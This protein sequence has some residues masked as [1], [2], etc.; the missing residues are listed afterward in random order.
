MEAITTAATIRSRL[1]NATQ[2]SV[3]TAAKAG[4]P[5]KIPVPG[6]TTIR[7]AGTL[8]GVGDRPPTIS[9]SS[10]GGGGGITSFPNPGPP[11]P[12]GLPN[13]PPIRFGHPS[14]PTPWVHWWLKLK[15]FFWP[16]GSESAGAK[17]G[18]TVKTGGA[19]IKGSLAAKALAA[20]GLGLT[21]LIVA[22]HAG[23]ISAVHTVVAQVPH[24]TSG[25]GLGAHIPVG[26]RDGGPGGVDIRLSG[27][28]SI[29]LPAL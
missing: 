25:P 9:L 21:G 19:L 1:A 24:W 28:G 8:T 6:P 20:F 27:G 10:M 13:K 12:V 14:S 7:V 29:G 23:D 15:L 4:G 22:A 26:Q 11:R 2:S 18:S 5:T 3:I 16:W 17:L